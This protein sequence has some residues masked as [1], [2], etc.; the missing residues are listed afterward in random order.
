VS[1]PGDHKVIPRRP[2][3]TPAVLYQIHLDSVLT[4]LDTSLRRGC[5]AKKFAINKAILVFA[6]L[7]CC[8]YK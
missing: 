5:P 1:M 3:Y 8:N 4:S 2:I 6:I 7:K